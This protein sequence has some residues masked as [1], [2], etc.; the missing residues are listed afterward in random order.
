MDVVCGRFGA[1]EG[2]K[3]EMYDGPVKSQV[4][5]LGHPTVRVTRISVSTDALH[6]LRVDKQFYIVSLH[7]QPAK[8]TFEDDQVLKNVKKATIPKPHK[9][10]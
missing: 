2:T 7:S 6:F 8:I 3:P 5:N 1:E 4:V 10:R 9:L